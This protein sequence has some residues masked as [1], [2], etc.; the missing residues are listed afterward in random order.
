M[1]KSKWF[2]D[3]EMMNDTDYKAAI[4][5]E[6]SGKLLKKGFAMALKRLKKQGKSV[7]SPDV[8]KIDSFN[9]PEAT[10]PFL[11]PATDKWMRSINKI[12]QKDG[13]LL[14]NWNI[15]TIR[16]V[17]SLSDWMLYIYVNG[18]YKQCIPT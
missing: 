11:K 9:V 3:I 16:Y 17:R 15:E 12:T 6:V 8:D 5:M 13:Y 2:W 1:Q 10:V 18:L 4:Y 7:G 14:V